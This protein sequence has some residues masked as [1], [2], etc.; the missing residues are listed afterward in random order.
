MARNKCKNIQS[1][2]GRIDRSRERRKK[3]SDRQL[4][5]EKK[6]CRIVTKR[7]NEKV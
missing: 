4:I 7:R 6:K 5:T 2:D 3:K 1:G